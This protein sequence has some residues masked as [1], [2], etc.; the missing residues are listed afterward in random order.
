MKTRYKLFSIP[1]GRE[2]PAT[3]N[4]QA[5]AISRSAKLSYS[6][7]GEDMIVDFLFNSML[8]IHEISYLD[9]GANH[10][11][12]LNNT[13]YFYKKEFTG[14][15]VDP[16]PLFK[17]AYKDIRP[18]DVH[19]VAG[20][21]PKK[22]NLDFYELNPNTLST[23]S[24]K[25][26]DQ[27]TQEDGHQLVRTYRVPVMTLD[28]VI[29]KYLKNKPLPN[30]LN[31]DIEGWDYDILQSNRFKKWRPAVVCA[32]TVTYST[33]KEQE[34]IAP[35]FKLFEDLGYFAYADTFINTIF[36]D[37]NVWDKRR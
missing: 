30:F 19:V 18:N 3:D 6:Q 37:K 22:G 26:A 17:K 25:S 10:P 8:N 34:K 16:N 5:S 24:K 12:N 28:E 21:G 9:I 11:I 31:L 2:K 36:V 35:L 7:S 15:C 1:G 4:S 13:Y 23:F 32:E 14:V 27:F 20:V 33:K 29:G